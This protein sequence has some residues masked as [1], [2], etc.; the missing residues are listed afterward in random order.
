M[1][2]GDA[3]P[4][5]LSDG[6]LSGSEPELSTPAS[7][8]AR[9]GRY[10]IC[11]KIGAG[12]MGAIYLARET[13]PHG[14]G[15]YVAL[16]RMHPKLACERRFVEMFFDEAQIAAT[17]AHPYVAHVH[18]FGKAG[19]WFYIAMEYLIGEPLSHLI[20]ASRAPRVPERD[21]APILRTMVDFC[22]A[23]HAAHELRDT[24][25][26][27]LD[28]VHRDISPGNLIV[29]YDGTVR[30]LDFGIARKIGALHHSTPGA[31]RGKFAYMAPEELQDGTV[32]R[33]TDVW[34]LGVVLWEILTGHRLFGSA[35]SI[36]AALEVV[37]DRFPVPSDVDRTIPSE[38]DA[39]LAR[40]LA[41]SPQKRYPT[42][43]EFGSD[44][45]RFLHRRCEPVG[46]FEVA[47]W[48]TRLFPMGRAR[49]EQ[50]LRMAH[51]V[52]MNA[53]GESGKLFVR[54]G[55]HPSGVK[56]S[57]PDETTVIE[58]PLEPLR[59]SGKM[60]VSRDVSIEGA[61]HL[62]T[63]TDPDRTHRIAFRAGNGWSSRAL[64]AGFCVPMVAIGLILLARSGR[65]TARDPTPP[66]ARTPL[67]MEP[68][69]NVDVTVPDGWVDVYVDGR[70]FGQAPTRVPITSGRRVIELRCVD[71]V[72]A[73][74]AVEQEES[75]R[76]LPIGPHGEHE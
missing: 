48:L 17:L 32:D 65:H 35:S 46:H 67:A 1:T 68:L 33:R 60:S 57:G 24:D 9:I 4:S 53:D 18:D 28:V 31:L 71:G 39:I 49:H 27:L 25:G 37:N 8:G 63:A 59:S 56:A 10:L 55:V 70:A 23:L 61:R 69:R 14:L 11:S 2:T 21:I 29:L 58:S 22:E 52:S 75:G 73:L 51:I 5:D 38:L 30:L 15:R 41:K 50:L 54:L 20:G 36:E 44:L 64:I 45:I 6:I 19:A 3:P 47:A 7:V 16:K 12:G 26:R 72:C 76:T 62:P 13:G 74:H 40:A 66:A 43:R 34:A 42:A